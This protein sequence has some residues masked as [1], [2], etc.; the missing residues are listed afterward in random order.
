MPCLQFAPIYES[1]SEA[2]PEI[3]FGKVNA[4]EEPGLAIRFNIQSVPTMVAL[5]DKT[6]VFAEAGAMPP[7]GLA[8]VI[9]K[10]SSLDMD[11]VRSQMSQ[12]KSAQ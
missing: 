1:M 7:A 10:V 6:I 3:L 8:T 5:R 4:E 11:D 12:Q 2:H 9:D